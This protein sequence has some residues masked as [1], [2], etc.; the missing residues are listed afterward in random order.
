[1]GKLLHKNLP[2]RISRSFTG[3][4]KNWQEFRNTSGKSKKLTGI[5]KCLQGISKPSGNFKNLQGNQKTL[6]EIK[7]VVRNSQFPTRKG[8]SAQHGTF[9]A[10]QWAVA[11]QH[12]PQNPQLY[13]QTHQLSAFAA[14]LRP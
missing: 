13:T 1:M 2:V 3:K 9:A 5:Q 10:Q 14:Q 7:K 8:I 11:T 12:R 6:Q 4:E